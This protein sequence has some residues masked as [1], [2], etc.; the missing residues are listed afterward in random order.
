MAKTLLHYEPNLG[1][2]SAHGPWTMGLES[3]LLNAH[4]EAEAAALG[5]YPESPNKGLKRQTKNTKKDKRS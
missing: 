2:A 5:H 4:A 1:I 3:W